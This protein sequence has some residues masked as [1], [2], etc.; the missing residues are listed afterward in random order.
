MYDQ[1]NLKVISYT[2]EES[3]TIG[4]NDLRLEKFSNENHG[5]DVSFG[6]NLPVYQKPYGCY[7]CIQNTTE[8]R[9]VKVDNEVYNKSSTDSDFFVTVQPDSGYMYET[10]K[11]S[12][13]F[14]IIGGR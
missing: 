12:T 4:G 6:Y 5:D 10:V 14:M 1:R 9:S 3:K 7:G 13:V 11:N 8:L 2:H